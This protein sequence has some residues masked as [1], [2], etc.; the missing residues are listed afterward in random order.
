VSFYGEH[1][2]MVIAGNNLKVYDLKE[3]LVREVKG[4][5]DKVSHFANFVNTIRGEAK[6]NADIA[7]GHKSTFL[8]HLGNISWRTGRTINFD[9]AANKIVDDQAADAYWKREYRPGW[10]PRV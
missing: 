6:L 3:K 10:E 2:S 1:G 9:P 4:E 7:D 5:N 8:T